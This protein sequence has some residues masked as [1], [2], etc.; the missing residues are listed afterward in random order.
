MINHIITNNITKFA[1]RNFVL[2]IIILEH[3]EACVVFYNAAYLQCNILIWMLQNHFSNIRK[4]SLSIEIVKNISAIM[5]G[6]IRVPRNKKVVK[7]QNISKF[8][9]NGIIIAKYTTLVSKNI[10]V[11]TNW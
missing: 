11:E 4:S 1:S 8:F 2:I 3:V 9:L 10:K 7:Y 6:I 5:Q